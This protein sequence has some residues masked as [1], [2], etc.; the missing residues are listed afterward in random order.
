M[1]WWQRQKTLVPA[2]RSL[3]RM[4]GCVLLS[5][6]RGS[7]GSDRKLLFRENRTLGSSECW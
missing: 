5:V 2:E 6:G 1:P 4:Y 7:D 3:N